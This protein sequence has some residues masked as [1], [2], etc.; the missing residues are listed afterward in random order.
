[1]K[2]GDT[3][4]YS[5]A[6]EAPA[7]QFYFDFHGQSNPTPDVKVLTYKK[8]MGNAANGAVVAQFDGIDGWYLQN[9]SEQPVIMHL[10]LSG[11][12]EMRQDPSAA[13]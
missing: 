13:E 10:K 4:L 5:W 9:Q 8:G 3:L 1:M 11:F 7:D 2:A 12:Y 6:V